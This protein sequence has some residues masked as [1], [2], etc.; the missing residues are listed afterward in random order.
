MDLVPFEPQ[1][2]DFFIRR[3]YT[4]LVLI[5]IQNGSDFKTAARAGAADEID[6]GFEIG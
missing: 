4:R 6:D 3:C 2:V 5:G 1:P